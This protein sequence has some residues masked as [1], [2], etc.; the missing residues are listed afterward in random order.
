[1]AAAEASF[2]TSMRSMSLGFSIGIDSLGTPSTTYNG[3]L[4]PVM[5]AIPRTRTL[6][7]SPGVPLAEATFTPGVRPCSI[8]ATL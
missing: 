6:G 5:D 1:M 4:L 2:N 3:V 7:C 8:L